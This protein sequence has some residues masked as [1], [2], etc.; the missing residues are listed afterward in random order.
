MQKGSPAAQACDILLQR[1]GGLRRASQYSFVDSCAGAGGPTPLFE[2]LMNS[3][4][5]SAGFP[6]VRFVLTDLWPDLK[7]WE[8]ITKRSANVTAIKK[9]VDATRP[10]RLA[11]PGKKEC[12]IFNLCFHHFKDAAAEKVLRS[13]V[14][15]NDAFM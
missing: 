2:A 3:R 6:P 12:R 15:S 5:Q 7:A 10:S 11:E 1:L 8:A 4:L 9:P 14:E 13:A